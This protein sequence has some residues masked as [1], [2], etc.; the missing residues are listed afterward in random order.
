MK[1]LLFCLASLALA[2]RLHAATLTVTTTNNVSPAATDTSLLQA[3]NNLHDGDTVQFGIPGPGPFYIPTPTDGYPLITANNV[4]IDGYSQPGSSPN[5]NSILAANSARI[6]IVLDSRDSSGGRTLLGGLNNP[7]YGV[8]ES[9]ILALRG[10]KNVRIQGLSFLSRHTARSS[11]DPDIY[12]VAFIDD[13][14]GA[15]ISGCWFGV[16][17]NGTNVFGGRSSVAAFAGDNGAMASGMVIGTN[18][19]GTND[20]AEFNV[21]AGMGLAI[22]LETPNVKVS[23]NFINVLPDGRTFFDGSTLN[24]GTIEAIENG[25]ADNMVIG[26]DGDGVSDANERNIIGPIFYTSVAQFWRSATNIVLAGNYVGVTFTGQAVTNACSLVDLHKLSDIRIGSN[27]DGTSDDLEGNW[28]FN[29]NPPSPQSFLQ[30]EDDNNDPG[31]NVAKAVVRGNK[32]VNIASTIPL[33]ASQ[34]VAIGTFYAQVLQDP[35]NYLP[36]LSTNTTRT[37]LIGSIPAASTN[38]PNAMIDVYLADPTGEA[39]GFPQGRSYLGSLVDNSP[40]DADPT[41]NQF[42]FDISQWPLPLGGNVDLVVAVTYSKDGAKTD[43]GRAVTSLF[44]DPIRVAQQV[45]PPIKLTSIALTATNVTLDWT[46]GVSPFQVQTTTNLAAAAWQT[47]VL[48]TNQNTASVAVSG[49]AG[50]FRIQGH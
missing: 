45:L 44:S 38:Y 18:G 41:P 50:F 39:N 40:A 12:C 16:D 24:V 43:S 48:V 49:K 11:D 26:T 8:T 2:A 1:K 4:T 35:N 32:L 15:Q 7:G 13:A 46:N 19:D 29:L 28:I 30:F 10:A 3:L 27:F 37:R 31:D 14:T 42:A 9:A 36:V 25:R 17:P 20:V 47:V 21:H 34:N 23:G 6:R 22:N 5:T 33:A